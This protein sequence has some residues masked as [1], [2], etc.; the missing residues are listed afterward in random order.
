MI[1]RSHSYAYPPL[2]FADDSSHLPDLP[3][4]LTSSRY[5]QQP[6]RSRRSSASAPSGPSSL[7]DRLGGRERDRERERERADERDYPSRSS[8]RDRDRD[9]D[10]RS[11]SPPARAPEILDEW[12]YRPSPSA[13]LRAAAPLMRVADP[14]APPTRPPSFVNGVPIPASLPRRPGPMMVAQQNVPTRPRGAGVFDHRGSPALS[15][16]SRYPHPGVQ[17]RRQRSETPPRERERRQR[18]ETPPLPPDRLPAKQRRRD[19]EEG[20]EPEE[21]E[22]IELEEGEEY[23]EGEVKPSPRLRLR[24]SRSRSRS[25]SPEKERDRERSPPR[26]DRSASHSHSRSRTRTRSRTHTRSRS[27]TRSPSPRLRSPSRSR[28]RSR[29]PSRSRSASTPPIRSPSPL[30]SVSP[31]YTPPLPSRPLPP[32]AAMDIDRAVLAP[33]E[34]ELTPPRPPPPRPALP[35]EPEEGEE[36]EEYGPE[37]PPSLRPPVAELPPVEV[38]LEEEPD[39]EPQPEDD[40]ED[41]DMFALPPPAPTPPPVEAKVEVEQQVAEEEEGTPPPRTAPLPP[42]IPVPATEEQPQAK[43]AREVAFLPQAKDEAQELPAVVP[44]PPTPPATAALPT[45]PPTSAALLPSTPAPVVAA[46]PIV[47]PSSSAAPPPPGPSAAAPLPPAPPAAATAATALSPPVPAAKPLVS[48]SMLGRRLLPPPPPPYVPPAPAPP[49]PAPVSEGASLAAPAPVPAAQAQAVESPVERPPRPSPETAKAALPSDSASV[50]PAAVIPPESAAAPSAEASASTTAPTPARK[51][52]V[53]PPPPPP[54]VAPQA[55]PA[56]P[57]PRR[58][59]EQT[60][61][62]KETTPPLV[63]QEKVDQVEKVEDAEM[64]DAEQTVAVEQP[65]E[66]VVAQEEKMAVDEEVAESSPAVQDQQPRSPTPPPPPQPAEIHQQHSPPTPQEQRPPTPPLS[67]FGKVLQEVIKE[68]EAAADE[69][70]DVQEDEESTAQAPVDRHELLQPTWDSFDEPHQR[71]SAVLLDSFRER[72]DRRADKAISLRQQYKALNADWKEHVKRLDDIRD[73]AHR[74]QQGYHHQSRSVP[75]TPSIDSAG[76]PFFPEPPTPGPSLTG[77]RANRRGGASTLGY[78]DAVRSEAEFLEILA[79]L[80]TAD[81][82]DPDVRAAR[83]AA[84]VP[85]MALDPTERREV[86]ETEFDDERYRV[87]DPV[88]TYGIHAPLDVWTEQEVE[89]FCKR[90][91]QHPKQFGKIAQDLPDKSPAQ[92]VLFYYRMKNTIDFRSLSDRRGRDGRRKKTK[93]R[94]EEARGGKGSSLLSNLKRPAGKEKA[95]PVDDDYAMDEDGP[96]SPKN[97]RSALPPIAESPATFPS[98]LP[99]LTST[100]ASRDLDHLFAD[101]PSRRPSLPPVPA[102][103]AAAKPKT[104]KLSHAQL[105][106]SEGTMEAAELLGALAA[107]A[108]AAVEE[109]PPVPAAPEEGKRVQ[110]AAARKVRM[111]LD[112]EVDSPPLGHLSGL[113]LPADRLVPAAPEEG[114]RVQRAA[115]RKVRMDL[116]DEVDSPPLGH[117]SGLPLPADR[118]VDRDVLVN[119]VGASDK[120]GVAG[121]KGK[122]KRKSNTSSYWTVAERNEITRLLGIYGKD[123]KKLAEGLGNKTWVQCR[124][125]YQNNAKKHALDDVVGNGGSH[126]DDLDSEMASPATSRGAFTAVPPQEH[127]PSLPRSGYFDTP[128]LPPLPSIG[129]PAPRAATT[130]GKAGMQLRNM[131]NAEGPDDRATTPVRDDWFGG[132]ENGDAASATTEDDVEAVAGAAF[133]R[134]DPREIV[135]PSSVPYGVDSV[136]ARQMSTGLPS[137]F[138]S[139]PQPQS[140][141]PSFPATLG[142]RRYDGATRLPS[143]NGVQQQ[144]HWTSRSPVSPFPAYGSPAASASPVTPASA[145]ASAD[146]YRTTY[147]VRD[148]GAAAARALPDYF[149]VKAFPP[150]SSATSAF[151]PRPSSQQPSVA[152]PLPPHWAQNPPPQ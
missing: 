60:K 72:D 16:V 135:R 10:R 85:D 56:V 146:Y 82:R 101:D 23:E 148:A 12:D 102:A 79:S 14:S 91:A 67:P 78:G 5:P 118:L 46:A 3:L 18:T 28:S 25:R 45:P 120:N 133:A 81:L 41:V 98:A 44:S 126:E 40:E 59:E 70:M 106:P 130:T 96:P 151:L 48:P 65:V 55:P 36:E 38:E 128:N 110:R 99:A 93:K 107:P 86:F 4:S 26:Y 35:P 20:E 58:A 117:L 127:L 139:Q 129:A 140:I 143:L 104:P 17:T 49:P 109:T 19:M 30:R 68:Q 90:Y 39:E 9:R 131:L 54:F 134:S 116:D 69:K 53:V 66:V 31:S 111:D 21:G 150:S 115:A 113:P 15:A 122:P 88:E 75:Q 83:T 64:R 73:R 142:D 13:P 105:L 124:N 136:A 7:L 52:H 132:G 138:R 100:A 152:A 43:D 145:S 80:E 42:L 97:V 108:D 62:A 50:P 95:P 89:A 63:A 11:A 37:L 119:G 33:E 57:S 47:P 34:G 92:C 103:S 51:G 8:Y 71:L 147:D 112:D 123:W 32:T 2:R 61:V 74:R 125:W 149:G 114:K 144:Q 6:S 76:M 141:L 94:P 77:G 22:E 87:V 1:C 24:R 29:S 27:P 137:L 84:V 121:D